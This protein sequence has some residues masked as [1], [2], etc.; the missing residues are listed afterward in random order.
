MLTLS[1]KVPADEG[2][3]HILQQDDALL[4]CYTQEVIEPVIRK[5]V[6]TE[7]QQ[8]DTVLQFPSQGCAGKDTKHTDESQWE[9]PQ[10]RKK[11]ISPLSSKG[12]G[13]GVLSQQGSRA[14]RSPCSAHPYIPGSTVQSK[15]TK[16][17]SP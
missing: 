17:L 12:E 14:G 4:R 15:G 11:Q 10:S 1:S 5:A 16:G 6:V 13:R 2:S 3:I 9:S 7:A 8:A